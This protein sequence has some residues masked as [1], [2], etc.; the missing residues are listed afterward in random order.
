MISPHFLCCRSSRPLMA[1]L[2]RTKAN[3]LRNRSAGSAAGQI[4]LGHLAGERDRH[5]NRKR[6]EDRGRDA[7]ASPI[8]RPG[9][10]T[11]CRIACGTRESAVK[12][13]I[14]KRTPGEGNHR[15]H[16][17]KWIQFPHHQ[18]KAEHPA[19]AGACCDRRQCA[20]ETGKQHAPHREGQVQK[21]PLQQQYGDR[22]NLP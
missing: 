5:W 22:S 13:A 20:T 2:N 18:P 21:K 17:M 7:D 1:R 16:K 6:D 10:N 14:F 4:T 8:R 3:A 19:T 12:K 15:H 9:T 11:S